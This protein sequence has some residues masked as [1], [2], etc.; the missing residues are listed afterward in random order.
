MTPPTADLGQ[1][2]RS[3]AIWSYLQ[4]GLGSVI[5]FGSGII[6][7]RLLNP[8]DFGVFFAVTA[9]TVFLSSQIKFGIPEALLQARELEETQW[10][11]AFWIMESVALLSMVIVFLGAPLL[12]DFY[13]DD[14][15]LKIAYLMAL[16]FPVIPFMS[17]NGTLLRRRMD[18]KTGSIIQIKSS[19]LATGASIVTAFLG[20][21]P[22]CFVVG[23]LT[24][25]LLSSY[26]MARAA[27]WHPS[28]DFQFFSFKKLFDYAWRIH[29]NNSIFTLTSRVD[30][31]IMGKLVGLSGLGLFMRAKS[32]AFLPRENIVTPIY[33]LAFSG[34][35]RIQ[36]DQQY[37]QQMYQ[38]IICATT[39]AVYPLLLLFIFLG[40]GLIL[41]LYGE[42]WLPAALPFKI[43]T[44]GV[45]FSVITAITST[46]AEAN[47]LVGRQTPIEIVNLILTI[48]AVSIGA[49]WGLT[50]IAVGFSAK[51]ITISQ[52][53]LRLVRTSHLT[54]TGAHLFPA[55][56]PALTSSMAG[57]ILGA[58]AAS[59]A[60][61]AGIEETS[62]L[63]MFLVGAAIGTAYLVTWLLLVLAD[64]DNAVLQANY[65][66][67]RQL[68]SRLLARLTPSSR[69]A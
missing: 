61:N 69:H 50:G 27:P 37:S 54:I 34:F 60:T 43:L 42:K 6:L 52:L 56:Y 7:A 38:K 66:L 4:G 3:G 24:G 28:R 14:R 23:G 8:D 25:T 40:D 26:M 13:E 45:F 35:S 10:N 1:Q 47:N 31:M 48:A 58:I 20:F 19:F 11:S 68:V 57:A 5:Q 49:P 2:M 36:H 46:L 30:S 22:Y 44:I 53:T 16:S 51:L 18:F 9:Y 63:Y 15:Y 17:I 32:L 59:L 33:Q 62:L 67:A 29:L 55:L 12:S 21:G 64:K 39:S 65:Q 41:H